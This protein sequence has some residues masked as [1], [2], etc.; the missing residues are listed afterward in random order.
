MRTRHRMP[1]IFSLSMMDVFC[2]TL[3]CVICFG[4]SISARRCSCGAC[5][6]SAVTDRAEVNRALLASASATY[7]LCC[8]LT[9]LRRSPAIAERRR[10]HPAT[11]DTARTCSIDKRP[12][13]CGCRGRSTPKTVWRRVL[14]GASYCHAAAGRDAQAR[15]RPGPA[16]AGE[17][18]LRPTWA[19][20]RADDLQEKAGSG[21]RRLERLKKVAETPPD[22]RDAAASAVTPLSRPTSGQAWS[23]TWPTPACGADAASLRARPHRADPRASGN[24]SMEQRFEGMAYWKRVGSIAYTVRQHDL[25]DDGTARRQ[26]V[27]RASRRADD[28]VG[29]QLEKLSG[30][31]VLRQRATW[32]ARDGYWA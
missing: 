6:A 20:K 15:C 12:P 31:S 21:P 16:D 24:T 13:T 19:A 1:M 28:G 30:G 18:N 8:E 23:A 9:G 14:A 10:D 26:V 5:S 3:G 7:D 25:I 2:C 32:S 17:R 4:S 29:P 11:S 22:L 27:E